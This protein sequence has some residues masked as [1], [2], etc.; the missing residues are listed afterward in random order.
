MNHIIS[1]ARRNHMGIRSHN[2]YVIFWIIIILVCTSLTSSIVSKEEK[3]SPCRTEYPD[4]YI[5]FSPMV[6][7]I[8]Y[9][10]DYNGNVIH[11]WPNTNLPGYA[12]YPLGNGTILRA[13]QHNHKVGGMVQEIAWNGDI[14]WQY[15]YDSDGNLSHHDIKPLPNGDVLIVAW[16][17][18]T[19]AETIAAGRNPNLQPSGPL[20]PDHIIE[21][22][23]TGPTSGDIVWEWHAWDHI[24]QEYD[25]SKENYGVVAD[26]PELIDINFI[27][28]HSILISDWTHINTV[29][30][31]ENLDQILLSSWYFNEIWVIDHSTTTEEAA[32]H[33]GGRC[34]RGGDLLYRWGNPQTY[35]A[36]TAADQK[37]FGQ[38][39]A[40]W[41]KAGCPGYGDILVFNNG[42]DRPAGAYSSVEE[43]TPPLNQNGT[44]SYTPGLPYQPETQRWIYTTANPT[45]FYSQTISGCQRLTNGDTLICNG[46][47][48]IFFE[49]TADKEIIWEF[50]NP[51]PNYLTNEVFKIRYLPP[52]PPGPDLN[53]AGEL[54]W[55]LVPPGSLQTGSF[56][57]ANIGEANSKL[58]WGIVRYPD[59]GNW[60][61][62][63]ASG[64]NLTPE[65]GPVTVQVEVFAPNQLYVRFNGEI[66]I[67][68]LQDSN[69]YAVIPLSLTTPVV[70]PHSIQQFQNINK[71]VHFLISLLKSDA[72]AFYGGNTKIAVSGFNSLNRHVHS[73][74]HLL[75][76]K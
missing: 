37:F 59:W 48:G 55:R 53:G 51:Y 16:E 75:E 74:H 35:Q 60:S 29:D 57:V 32:G 44:Y 20:T 66:K 14:L 62:T 49:V 67:V 58:H 40:Q 5:L 6:S 64:Q 1:R 36:G 12:V 34:G 15:V 76:E 69:D 23:P 70:L 18:K 68:N 7:T 11:T 46:I 13:A 26:H 10:I 45:D 71:V 28:Q 4:G 56:T 27:S 9:Q 21:V 17:S 24:V 73:N 31:N 19:E 47:H 38:H 39:D 22:K 3:N 72:S 61:F 63:P 52:V 41:I 30:Y 25:P 33:T 2:K 8:T 50:T 65:E 42:L 54:H 43:I